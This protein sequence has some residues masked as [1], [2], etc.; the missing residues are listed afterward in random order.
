[1]ASNL[2]NAT[3]AMASNLQN[4]KK[5][6]RKCF[7]FLVSFAATLNGCKYINDVFQIFIIESFIMLA[8]LRLSVSRV[9]GAYLR[10]ITLGQQSYF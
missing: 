7:N 4:N 6:L 10:V 5:C 3:D 2:Q 1:M 9:R 8:V